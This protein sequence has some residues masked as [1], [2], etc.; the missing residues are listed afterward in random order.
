MRTRFALIL[1]VRM[2][3]DKAARHTVLEVFFKLMITLY[4]IR[5]LKILFTQDLRL[6]TNLFCGASSSSEPSVFLVIISFA[7][8]LS[9]F[10]VIS[11][12]FC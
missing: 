5:C 7:W 6:K 10:K 12:L 9:P 1:Y 11:A 4:R 3:V 8:G 2:T